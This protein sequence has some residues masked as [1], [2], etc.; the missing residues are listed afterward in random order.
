M[1]SFIHI[2]VATSRMK[3]KCIPEEQYRV[4][5]EF[6]IKFT[7]TQEKMGLVKNSLNLLKSIEIIRDLKITIVLIK[8]MPYWEINCHEV[9]NC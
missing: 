5:E 3:V 1:S 2:S 6:Y 8:I 9:F 4:S 7:S